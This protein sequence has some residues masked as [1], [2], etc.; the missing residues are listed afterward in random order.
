MAVDP[1]KIDESRLETTFES[2]SVVV[3]TSYETDRAVK[4]R[5]VEVRSRWTRI[6]E[7]G[8]GAFGVVWL[9]K[10]E[11]G[12][13]RAV[14]GLFRRLMKAQKI[15]FSRELQALTELREVSVSNLFSACTRL[16]VMI[17]INSSLYSSSAGTMTK[18]ISISR[19]STSSMVTWGDISRSLDRKQERRLRRSL[20]NFWKGLQ[21]YMKSGSVIAI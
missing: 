12:D 17:S 18:S 14:K 13:K 19:W 10:N 20:T 21:S 9:E 4:R 16:T 1:L 7:I 8:S 2:D 5:R 11:G 15:D 3:H 6:K